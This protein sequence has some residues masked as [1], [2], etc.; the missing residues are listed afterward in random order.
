MLLPLATLKVSEGSLLSCSKYVELTFRGDVTYFILDHPLSRTVVWY[1]L[2]NDIYDVYWDPAIE[3][4]WLRRR[5]QC[6]RSL[7]RS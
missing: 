7:G 2:L 3:P 1:I 5:L 6:R 4:A